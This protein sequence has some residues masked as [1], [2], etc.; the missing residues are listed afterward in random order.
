MPLDS[1]PL[2]SLLVILFVGVS[3]WG[4]MLVRRITGIKKLVSHH[5]VMGY[6]FPV[7][8][9]TYGILLG[10]VVVNSITIF[11][12][13]RSIVNNEATNLVE[14]YSLANFLPKDKSI[15]IQSLCRDYA[16]SI[17]DHEWDQMHEGVSYMPSREYTIELFNQI[18]STL[19]KGYP[20][21]QK[22]LDL[23]EEMW[24]ERRNRVDLASRHIPT[25]EWVALCLGGVLVVVFSYMFV[26]DSLVVQL[27]GTAVIST[28][29]GL[30]IFLI[31]LF[32]NPFSGDLHVS[33]KPF[34]NAIDNFSTID[35][36]KAVS[37]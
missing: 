8:G 14:I 7:A 2:G 23:L 4:A 24:K 20:V 36:I 6:F 27:F 18:T 21:S 13:A 33:D 25:V 1:Y 11:D 17:V 35:K 37:K 12:E 9:S 32:A 30:N 26:M 16:D 29:I 3:I 31:L 22:M 34:R 19:E 10:L 15:A 28:M 5:E